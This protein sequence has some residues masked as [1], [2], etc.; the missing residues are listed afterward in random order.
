MFFWKHAISKIWIE[1]TGSQWNSSGKFPRIHNIGNSWRNSKD[2]SHENCMANSKNVAACANKFPQ[3]C[4]SFLGLVCEKVV[5]NTCQQAKWW[6]EQNCWDHDAPL[7]WQLASPYFVPPAFGG[8]WK[9]KG[10]GKKSIQFNWG[11]KK[12]PLNW[13]LRTVNSV[14]QL[15]IYRAVADVCKDLSKDSELAVKLETNEDLESMEIPTDLP[16]ADRGV[17]GKLA[18]RWSWIRPTSWRPEMCS[19]AGLKIVGKGQFFIALDEEEEG[20]D[21]MNNLGREYTSPRSGEASRVRGWI[22][23]NTKIGPVLHVKVCLHQKRYGIE[24]SVESLL[25]DRKVSWV[26]IVNG[27]NKN[28]NETSETSSLLKT[29]STELQETLL[30]KQSHDQCPLWHWLPFLFLHVKENE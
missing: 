22:L 13:F 3:G 29:L 6:M 17:A 15:G 21:E 30:R 23:G 1:S 5:W 26:R 8:E 27:V 20:P 12:K 25:R 14:N 24:I 16:A 18:A 2:D 4:W 7:P 11:E 19:D 10:G 9:S 28:V